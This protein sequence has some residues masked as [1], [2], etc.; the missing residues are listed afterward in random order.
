M[1]HGKEPIASARAFLDAL[2]GKKCW[3]AV[4]G[5][6]TGSMVSF[7]FGEKIRR[8]R[9]LR[10]LKLPSD[11]RE[12]DSEYIVFVRGGA[13]WVVEDNGSLICSSDDSNEDGGVML[14]GLSLLVGKAIVST[15]GSENLLDLELLFEEGL[16]FQMT[17]R[18][19]GMTGYSLLYRDEAIA[20]VGGDI[21]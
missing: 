17:C 11:V 21:A 12:F 2:I 6:G 18:A 7:N 20:T 4:A 9:P 16:C 15:K 3:A 19:E 10:N 1:E 8:E 5:D 14:T 13:R